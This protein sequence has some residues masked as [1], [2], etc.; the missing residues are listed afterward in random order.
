MHERYQSCAECHRDVFATI[1]PA[2]PARL[3]QARNDMAQT[4]QGIV[5]AV[6]YQMTMARA[7]LLFATKLTAGLR[8]V[9]T[10]HCNMVAL[11]PKKA[12]RRF[13]KHLPGAPAPTLQPATPALLLSLT[14][15]SGEAQSRRPAGRV[16]CWPMPCRTRVLTRPAPPHA[17]RSSHDR[18]TAPARPTP[19][20]QAPPLDPAAVGEECVIVDSRPASTSGT[21]ASTPRFGGGHCRSLPHR[22]RPP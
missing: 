15:R 9:A 4:I 21:Y 13:I 12:H 22:V 10:V 20:L 11:P 1:T 7:L 14:R 19:L 18:L 3:T 6:M 2:R 5:F 16:R 8:G 17:S